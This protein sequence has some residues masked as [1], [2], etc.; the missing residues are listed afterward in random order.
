ML[1]LPNY[2]HLSQ[3]PEDYQIAGFMPAEEGVGPGERNFNL[4]ESELT[5]SANIDPYFAGQ[6]TAA[7]TPENEI[8]IEEAYFRTLALKSV[9]VETPYS[10]APSFSPDG[11]HIFYEG[12]PSGDDGGPPTSIYL[13]N[14]P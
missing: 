9:Q 3:D 8:E 10:G 7:I 12:G 6:L 4:G 1:P 14:T 5:M 2:A 13:T 11:K